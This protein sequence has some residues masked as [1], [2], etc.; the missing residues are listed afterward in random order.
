VS[1]TAGSFAASSAPHESR[2]D[3]VAVPA[4]V[5]ERHAVAQLLRDAGFDRAPVDQYEFER[6]LHE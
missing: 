2:P 3:L 5:P 4:V 1:P 6:P